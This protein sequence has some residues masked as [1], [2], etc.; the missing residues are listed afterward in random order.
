MDYEFLSYM[1]VQILMQTQIDLNLDPHLK[2]DALVEC[3]R[4][5]EVLSRLEEVWCSKSEHCL[6]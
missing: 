3:K 6:G 4:V 2:Q 5:K 1:S